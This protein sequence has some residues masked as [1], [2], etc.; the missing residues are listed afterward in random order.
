L[1]VIHDAKNSLG[2]VVFRLEAHGGCDVEIVSLSNASNSL[3]NLLVWHRQQDGDMRISIDSAS[4]TDL[5]NE[6][7]T[8]FRQFF[9]KIT[10]ECNTRYAPIFWFYDE[11]YIRLA[12][13][14]ALHNAC[15]YAKAKVQLST[16][17]VDG[18]LLFTV[19]DD[20]AGYDEAMLERFNQKQLGE[21]SRRGTGIGLA[22]AASIASL[23][24]NKGISGQVMLRNGSANTHG[25]IFELS[26]P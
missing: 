2:E 6:L 5:L 14:N 26:L 3:T 23:H 21:I 19:K 8:E 9:P 13:V 25:A 10:I 18:K 16:E 24:V 4:P 20:G 1:A 22:L 15:H 11:A 7:A 17:E 12:L